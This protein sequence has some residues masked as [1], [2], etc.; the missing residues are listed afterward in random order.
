VA[1]SQIEEQA[2]RRSI[3]VVDGPFFDGETAE[4]QQR[5]GIVRWQDAF[6]R[7]QLPRKSTSLTD[8]AVGL[9]TARFHNTQT[10]LC[11]PGAETIAGHLG[12]SE[13]TV[14]NAWGRLEAAGWLAWIRR[15][16]DSH[17]FV[18]LIPTPVPG[19]GVEPLGSPRPRN[20]VPETP[21]PGS[22]ERER[23]RS[24]SRGSSANMA[25]S[26]LG[27]SPKSTS[28]AGSVGGRERPLLYRGT[29]SGERQEVVRLLSAMAAENMGAA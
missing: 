3:F 24:S 17:Q 21:V 20:L 12:C 6:F 8:K 2:L 19:S 27:G 28:P 9:A 1:D 15:D 29:S 16:G 23:T 11:F 5:H 22:D 13:K 10:G 7:A 14:R 4:Q 18:F 25:S 26:P